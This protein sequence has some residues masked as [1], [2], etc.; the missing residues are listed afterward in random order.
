MSVKFCSNHRVTSK[1]VTT[2]VRSSYIVQEQVFDFLSCRS[3]ANC[4]WSHT[5]THCAHVERFCNMQA[6]QLALLNSQ[7]VA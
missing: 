6:Q 3:N 4:Y 1:Y 2:S 7:T 5:V